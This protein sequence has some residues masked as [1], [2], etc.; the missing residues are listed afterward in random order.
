MTKGREVPELDTYTFKSTGIKVY[1]RKVSQLL[2]AAVYRSNPPPKPPLNEVEVDDGVF[3]LEPNMQ[4]P[5]Y[6]HAMNAYSLD[7]GLKT[8]RFLLQRGVELMISEEEALATLAPIMDDFTNSIG[9]ALPDSD[10][11]KVA[12]IQYI[13]AGNEDEINEL[14]MLITRK[15]MPTEEV[16]SEAVESFRDNV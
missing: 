11:Y 8:M 2:L 1:Y 14:A 7:I 13:A 12:Y 16:I 15:S 5:T 4:D 10:N 6:I 3:K 9:S